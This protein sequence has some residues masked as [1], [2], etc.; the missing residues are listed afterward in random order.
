[1][2]SYV[3]TGNLSTRKIKNDYFVFERKTGV[4]HS[5]NETGAFLW[6]LIYKNTPFSSIIEILTEEFDI[7]E[8]SA[9][10]DVYDFIL[11]LQ[12]KQILEIQ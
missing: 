3:I 7:T 2:F 10:I 8:E 5:F 6:E 12:T 11:E 1:M 4:I 9:K